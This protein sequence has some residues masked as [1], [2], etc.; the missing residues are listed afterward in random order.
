MRN[1]KYLASSELY[2]NVDYKQPDE[3]FPA[4]TKEDAPTSVLTPKTQQQQR[5]RKKKR[6]ESDSI[7]TFQR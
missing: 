4:T 3:D 2:Q 6:T 1:S 5:R 7:R